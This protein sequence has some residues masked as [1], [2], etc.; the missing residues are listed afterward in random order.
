GDR[1]ID[2]NER[3]QEIIDDEERRIKRQDEIFKRHN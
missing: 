2:M 3:N 1:S